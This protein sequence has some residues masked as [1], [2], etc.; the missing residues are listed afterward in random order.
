MGISVITEA[1]LYFGAFDKAELRH[2]KRS[3]SSIEVFPVNVQVSELFIQL[4]EAY[5]LS[6]RLSI[7]DA[8]IGATAVTYDVELYTL[9]TK[10]FRYL[11]GIKLYQ[12]QQG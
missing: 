1:E 12:P 11:P 6:H 5:T 8:L 9:N 7:P 2:I 10:D 4:M 3:L